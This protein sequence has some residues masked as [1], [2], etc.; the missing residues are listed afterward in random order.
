MNVLP[1]I[2]AMQNNSNALACSKIRLQ[3]AL[4]LDYVAHNGGY[5]TDLQRPR[6]YAQQYKARH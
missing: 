2:V 6:D 5:D 4:F 1:L 3:Y